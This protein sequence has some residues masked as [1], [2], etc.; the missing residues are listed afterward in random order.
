MWLW[1]Y[2]GDYAG[3][4]GFTWE[5]TCD[6][7]IKL[8]DKMF[9]GLR[10]QNI[11]GIIVKGTFVHRRTTYPQWNV[12]LWQKCFFSSGTEIWQIY[13]CNPNKTGYQC[14]LVSYVL[15]QK[16]CYFNNGMWRFYILCMYSPYCLR[17]FGNLSYSDGLWS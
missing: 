17:T 16:S 9:Y 8:C 7:T 2:I 5:G 15:H 13:P 10:R 4:C 1:Y 6:V 14:I 3:S 11:W 12:W